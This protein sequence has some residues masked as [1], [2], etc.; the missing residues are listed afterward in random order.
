MLKFLHLHRSLLVLNFGIIFFVSFFFNMTTPAVFKLL[1]EGVLPDGNFRAFLMGAAVLLA[2]TCGRGL[3]G[4]VQDYVF[5]LHRQ[6]IEVAALRVGLGRTDLKTLNMQETVA[7]IRNFVANFQYFWIEFVFFIAYA[8]FISAVVLLAFYLIQ[9]AYFWL[10]LA[11]MLAHAVNFSVFR[12]AVER[13]AARFN[14]MKTELIAEM[15]AHARVLGEARAIGAAPFLLG[16]MDEHATRYAAAYRRRELVNFVQRLVQDGLINTFYVAFFCYAL[17]LS[18]VSTVSIGSA[19]LSIFLSSLLF[20][21]IYRFSAILKSYFEARQY[22]AWVPERGGGPARGS[23][24]AHGPLQLAGVRTALMHERGLAPLNVS[25]A[26]G[27]LHLI[28]G[29]SGC[30]K[31]TLLDC[32]AGVDSVGSGRISGD[33]GV[34]YCEQQAAIFPGSVAENLQF[35]DKAGADCGPLLAALNLSAVAGPGAVNAASTLSSGQKQRLAVARSLYCDSATVLYDEPTS[36]QDP[37]NE[38]AVFALLA[39][40]ARTRT[41]IVVSHSAR[42]RHHAGTV[43]DLGAAAQPPGARGVALPVQLESAT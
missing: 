16:R 38:Q 43:L 25:F 33:G 8:V 22:A 26:P 30:G 4:V 29:P 40:A 19:A 15:A 6:L 42:A 34:F 39:E 13:R 31:S 5:L 32:L 24:A 17:Y 18:T 7:S 36:A 3:F 12:P 23:G 41:V 37:D 10:S 20:E 9:P 35:F 28:V 11:F 1:I 2:V 27:R 21:P 14:Q